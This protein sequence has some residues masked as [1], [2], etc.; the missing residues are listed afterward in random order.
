METKKKRRGCAW[1]ILERDPFFLTS[2]ECLWTRTM[3]DL[4][5]K[6]RENGLAQLETLILSGNASVMNVRSVEMT[7]CVVAKMLD[8]AKSWISNHCY[9]EVCE[10]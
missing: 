1:H 10:S 9:V 7:W 5:Y 3:I 4:Y 8:K 2:N 6:E